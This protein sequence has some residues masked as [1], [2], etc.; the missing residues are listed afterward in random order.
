MMWVNE[1]LPPRVRL[2]WSLT[3]VRFSNMRRAGMSRT[4]V[5]V[6]ISSER[7]MFLAMA[8]PMPFSAVLPASGAS[9][10][11][12]TSMGDFLA[13][14]GAAFCG[15]RVGSGPFDGRRPVSLTSA[16]VAAARLAMGAGSWVALRGVAEPMR[17]AADRSVPEAF[18]VK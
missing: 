1:I 14:M 17:L 6:G 5:A 18:L 7:S 3:R 16:S 12:A 11:A 2:S 13:L 10:A 15:V 8:L 4:D 9:A